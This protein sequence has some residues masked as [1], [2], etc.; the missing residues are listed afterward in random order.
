MSIAFSW[1][2]QERQESPKSIV[3]D[4]SVIYGAV[5]DGVE[6]ALVRQVSKNFQCED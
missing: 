2:S 5:K 1:P 6:A 4:T 3:G